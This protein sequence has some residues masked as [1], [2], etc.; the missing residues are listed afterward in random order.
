M[1]WLKRKYNWRKSCSNFEGWN[2]YKGGEKEEEIRATHNLSEED[3]QKIAEKQ[4]Y[5]LT[6]TFEDDES[7]SWNFPS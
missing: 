5:G 7:L 2:I 4:W 1:W 3:Y 6:I